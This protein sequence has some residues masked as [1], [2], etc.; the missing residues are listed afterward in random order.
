MKVLIV[1]DDPFKSR[2]IQEYLRLIVADAYIEK[3]YSLH[4]AVNL[5]YNEVFDFVVLD[6]AIPSHSSHNGTSDVYS[7]P[8][9]GLD[10][11]LY[12]AFDGR[13]ERIM[14]LTQYPTVEYNRVHV[15]LNRL[16]VA[17][18]ADGINNVD[19]VVWFSED[20][21]WQDRLKKFIGAMS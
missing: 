14:I 10:I 19:D 20:E 11:L 1:E 9:G 16:L 7:Q 21:L 2:R 15:P 8:V 5:L 3:A 18:S 12:L 6:M 13:S 17:L 4:E